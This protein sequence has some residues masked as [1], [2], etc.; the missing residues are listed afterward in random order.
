MNTMPSTKNIVKTS[1]SKNAHIITRKRRKKF[2][3]FKWRLVKL[4]EIEGGLS[5]EIDKKLQLVLNNA[6][7]EADFSVFEN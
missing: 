3:N 6:G 5:D 7:E 1:S 4:V 2:S